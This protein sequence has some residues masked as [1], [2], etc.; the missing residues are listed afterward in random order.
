MRRP[1][2][3]TRRG[4]RSSRHS[5]GGIHKGT[6]RVQSSFSC[7]RHQLST[8]AQL[9]MPRE[10]AERL[11]NAARDRSLAEWGVRAAQSWLPF[12]P[13]AVQKAAFRKVVGTL[14][15]LHISYISSR[16]DQ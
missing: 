16:K 1:I 11:A 14:L 9:F 6:P 4:R 10:D 12:A 13:T 3:P 7:Q 15:T 2:H 5:A 8:L